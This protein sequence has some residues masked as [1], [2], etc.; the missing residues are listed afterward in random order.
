MKQLSVVYNKELM[1]YIIEMFYVQ[2]HIYISIQYKDNLTLDI[3]VYVD[4]SVMYKDKLVRI[5]SLT[6]WY[7][8]ILVDITVIYNNRCVH[9]IE[10]EI[11][12]LLNC[13][14]LTSLENPC[15]INNVRSLK[16]IL[17]SMYRIYSGYILEQV[18]FT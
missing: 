5:L 4:N 15:R 9:N 10:D 14:A 8:S 18:T 12:F 6:H 1:R 3:D 2:V 13:K 17:T 11:H 7:L 16:I